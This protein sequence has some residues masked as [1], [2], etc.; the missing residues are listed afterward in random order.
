MNPFAINKQFEEELCKYTG[1]K[2]AVTTNCCTNAILLVCQWL[3]VKEVS[4][5]RFTYVSTPLSVIQAGGKVKFDDR[6][7]LGEYQ[8]LPYP[9]WDS[10]RLFTSGMYEK[11]QYK[12]VSFHWKKT[13]AI[14]QGGAILHDNEEADKWFR[15]MRFH[16][17]TEGVAPKDDDVDVLGW[18]CYMPPSDAAEGLM[19]LSFLP[20]YNQPC[21]NE[22]TAD[23]SKYTI[24]NG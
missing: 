20:K 23:V 9:I 4:I 11:G 13:L 7:W 8:L 12:C 5:P 22:G 19:R 1:A 6:Q 21:S 16:G 10:A 17:R 15:K 14:G 2:F 24:F 18:H 3:K